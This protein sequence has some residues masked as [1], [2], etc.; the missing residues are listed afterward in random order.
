M[1]WEALL[2]QLLIAVG[3]ETGPN[4]GKLIGGAINELINDVRDALYTPDVVEYA[5]LIAAGV[6]A[7]NPTMRPGLQAELVTEGIRLLLLNPDVPRWPTPL[8]VS[9]LAATSL[10][11]A[12]FVGE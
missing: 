7:S 8:S 2:V 1:G 9:T 12:G 10:T 11:R 4:L 6:L 3:V 5:F